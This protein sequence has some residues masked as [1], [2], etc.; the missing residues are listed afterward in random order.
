MVEIEIGGQRTYLQ[1]SE[2]SFNYDQVVST[3]FVVQ[4]DTGSTDLWIMTKGLPVS[5]LNTTNVTATE[6][7]GRGEAA[8]TI[9]FAHVTM[10]SYAIPSQGPFCS[11][12]VLRLGH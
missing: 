10:G 5:I 2:V 6:T 4:L 11:I 8:G 1:P 3:D 9:D 12:S 7:Y